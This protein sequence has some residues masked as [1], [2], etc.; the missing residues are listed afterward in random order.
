MASEQTAADEAA[1]KILR[2]NALESKKT[3]EAERKAAAQALQ[4]GNIQA[5]QVGANPRTT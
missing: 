1:L 4:T 3:A 2:D 5:C